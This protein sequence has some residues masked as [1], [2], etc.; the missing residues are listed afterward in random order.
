MRRCQ[1]CLTERDLCPALP[2]FGRTVGVHR[3][4]MGDEA[5]GEGM[6]RVMRGWI[7]SSSLIKRG[8]G[9]PEW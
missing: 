1:P 4:L 3:C 8:G 7:V 9:V 6:G 2:L 5:G